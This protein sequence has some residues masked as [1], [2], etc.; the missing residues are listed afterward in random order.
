MKK[1]SK[2]SIGI[3]KKLISLVLVVSVTAITVIAFLSF[4]YATEILQSRMGD[5]LTSESTLRGNS[6]LS[7]IHTRIKE[8]QVLST[9]PM[10]RN[11]VEELNQKQNQERDRLLKQAIATVITITIKQK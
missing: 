3:D 10:I 8:T 9:D 11:L 5:Q 7:F 4:N 6:I 2:I 1:Q